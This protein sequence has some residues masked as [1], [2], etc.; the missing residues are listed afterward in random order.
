MLSKISGLKTVMNG[1]GLTLIVS[2]LIFVFLGFSACSDK[3]ESC[4]GPN[5][6]PHC[7]N[8]KGKQ[9][10]PGTGSM[11][12]SDTKQQS[13]RDSLAYGAEAYEDE[14]SYYRNPSDYP[15]PPPLTAGNV[16]PTKDR[17]PLPDQVRAWRK[18]AWIRDDLFAQLKLGEI[19]LNDSSF[20]D[21]VE[22]YVWYFLALS[23]DRLYALDR[24]IRRTVWALI[25]TAR[26][27]RAD[28]Y[29][30]LTLE[31]ILQARQR[32]IYILSCRGADGF[33]SLGLLHQHSEND[34]QRS[35]RRSSDRKGSTRSDYCDSAV[36]SPVLSSDADALM[37][38][39]IAQDMGHPLAASFIEVQKEVLSWLGASEQIMADARSRARN[40]RPDSEYYPGQTA[41]GM[42]HSDSCL[43]SLEKEQ[44]LTRM[45]EVPSSLIH[46][47][48]WN[49]GFLPSPQPKSTREKEDAIL[50]FQDVMSHAR[51]GNLSAEEQLR[52]IQ[53]GAVNGDA[54][55]QTALGVMYSKGI[56]VVLN[57]PRAEKWFAQAA[58]QRRGEALYYLGVLYK[59][60]VDG[61]PQDEDKAARLFTD[62]G[63][64]NYRPVKH[65]LMHLLKAAKDE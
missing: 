26:K 24:N 47:A 39:Y 2:A 27:N 17:F 4:Q 63:L 43:P 15:T 48:L 8:Y 3:K 22:A 51:S 23:P 31:Q 49:A 59:A 45:H 53:T 54:E 62:A 30:R 29:H 14:D 16:L 65:Q 20:H 12:Q 9:S 35:C 33:I 37:Y 28:V 52:L 56:G 42:V 34:R 32:I 1:A 44:A 64:A 19:Y 10:Q 58:R 55:L 11:H 46:R 18:A 13:G 50:R 40:W 7:L 61:V 5:P 57:Y 25:D 38:F 41:G 21:P 60:G 36:P 6:G